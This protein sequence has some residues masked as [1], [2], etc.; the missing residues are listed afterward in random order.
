MG[1][2]RAHRPLARR[3]AGPVGQGQWRVPGYCSFADEQVAGLERFLVA[4]LAFAHV[5]EG[6]PGRCR[7]LDHPDVLDQARRALAELRGVRGEPVREVVTGPEAEVRRD[8][9]VPGVQH[10]EAPAEMTSAGLEQVVDE[11]DDPRPGEA[12]G[13]PG[14]PVLIG[15]PGHE[16]VQRRRVPRVG[17]VAQWA[18]LAAQFPAPAGQVLQE[19]GRFRVQLGL[20]GGESVGQVNHGRRRGGRDPVAERALLLGQVI[21][22]ERGDAAPAQQVQRVPLEPGLMYQA[23]AVGEPRADRHAHPESALLE[24][25]E[26]G[27]A[28]PVGQD[29]HPRARPEAADRGREFRAEERVPLRRVAALHALPRRD[30]GRA[31]F[32]RA[33]HGYLHSHASF[34]R[35]GRSPASVT[36]GWRPRSPAAPRAGRRRRSA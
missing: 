30:L 6:D 17:D 14:P 10:R 35:S 20:V 36:A 7:V 3:D 8:R 1:P 9:V 28:A 27:D 2:D 24:R 5:D 13:T 31:Q 18:R 12:V 4:L 16:G 25:E 23:L 21:E 15:L 19:L 34:S 11:P 33:N 29:G 22:V 26:P 32:V